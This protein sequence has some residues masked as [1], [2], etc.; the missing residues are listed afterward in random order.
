MLLGVVFVAVG[1]LGA[2]YVLYGGFV[3]RRL[4]VRE[5]RATP[6]HDLRDGRDYVPTRPGVLFGHHFSSIAGAGPIVGPVIASLAF[7]W[8]PAVIWIVLGAVLIGGVQD[9]SSLMV[10]IRHGARS[11]AEVAR[12]EISPLANTLFLIFVW[13]ALVYVIVVFVD[14]TSATFVGD[15][16]VASSSVLY[17]ALALLFGIL[18]SRFGLRLGAGS[19]VFVPL[20]FLGIWLGQ[21]VP[22][23]LPVADAGEMWSVVLLG[24]CLVASVLPVW[25]LLQPRDYLASYLL[26]ACLAGGLLGIVVMGGRLP[27]GID[28]LPAVVALKDANL[29]F[30]FP[31][32]F[33][34]IACGAVSGFH[35]IVASGTTAKQL[36]REAHARPV[37]YGGMILEGVLAVIAVST[38]IVV[39]LGQA[40]N[41]PPTLVFAQGLG[42]VTS[43]LGISQDVGAHFGALAISTFLLT[44][45]DTCTRLG[46]YVLE[47][48][49]RL[50]KRL[51]SATVA[52]LATLALPLILTQVTL[53]LPDGTPAPAWKVIWPVFGATNQLLGALALLAVTAW[54][55]NQGR[56][57]LFAAA[58]MFF[59][60]AVTLSALVQLV[61]RYGVG[62]FV[63]SVSLV[64]ALLALVILE[65]AI[66]LVLRF[67]PGRRRTQDSPALEA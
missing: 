65:E 8:L 2:G 62:T 12:Q 11:V 61:W 33:V 31:A 5:D 20:V 24:Y 16:G 32:L 52:T 47:E 58:P 64:L 50:E 7:G 54:L 49:L 14:L 39:G 26:F 10:S 21:K 44:T 48:L 9:F 23:I 55:R 43:R 46:R 28:P 51:F 30:L 34:T 45:L 37:A 36:D 53:R 29:G 60:F 57:H 63:G 27:T 42:V 56:R 59:M 41:L 18:I 17:I 13:V 6:A 35:S 22:L 67:P 15:P 25:L 38:V 1:L 66:R 4:G 40:R 3:A 19:L